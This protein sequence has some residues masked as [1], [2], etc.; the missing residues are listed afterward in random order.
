MSGSRENEAAGRHTP[1]REP[2]GSSS[3]VGNVND[4][5]REPPQ[6]DDEPAALGIDLSE[7]EGNPQGGALS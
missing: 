4:L 3:A 2:V 1:D 5:D 7:S 6:P